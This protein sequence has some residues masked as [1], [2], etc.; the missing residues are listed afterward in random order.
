MKITLRE[1]LAAMYISWLNDFGKEILDVVERMK[2]MP[3][4]MEDFNKAMEEFDMKGM[5]DALD[6]LN[7]MLME[8]NEVLNMTMQKV[9]QMLL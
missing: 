2:D 1:Q 6:E 5:R 8:V 3:E 7:F 9:D 4:V